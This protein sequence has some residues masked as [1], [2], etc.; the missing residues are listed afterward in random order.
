MWLSTGKPTRMV[1][2]HQLFHTCCRPHGW[3][4]GNMKGSDSTEG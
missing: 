4:M 2:N 1:A 3:A